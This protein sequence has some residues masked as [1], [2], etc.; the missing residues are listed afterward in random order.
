MT[1]PIV[2]SA[3]RLALIIVLCV[4]FIGGALL[5]SQAHFHRAQQPADTSPVYQTGLPPLW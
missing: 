1:R 2:H 5:F 4:G 3:S